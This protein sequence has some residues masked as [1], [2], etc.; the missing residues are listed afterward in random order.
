MM[1]KEMMGMSPMFAEFIASKGLDFVLDN[2][3]GKGIEQLKEMV[4]EWQKEQEQMK[5]RAMQMQEQEAQQNPAMLKAHVEMAKL[6]ED[7]E[8]NAAQHQVD[9][10]KIA[11]EREKIHA[12]LSMNETS[13]SVQLVKAQTER[14]VHKMDDEVKRHDQ[15]HRH[16]IEALDVHHRA[17]ET[18]HKIKQAPKGEKHA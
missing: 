3:E 10:A 14:A 5:Q 8:K 7:K 1:V 12:Q 13:A 2:M 16:L 11:V 9:M 15:S 18:H 6:Q 4:D 17:M